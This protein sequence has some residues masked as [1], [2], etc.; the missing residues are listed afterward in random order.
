MRNFNEIKAEFAARQPEVPYPFKNSFTKFYGY[1]AGQTIG[2]FASEREAILADAQVV[3]KHFDKP[4][5]DTAMVA[6]RNW[7][8][9]LSSAWRKQSTSI[10]H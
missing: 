4:A 5:Y 2:T 8:D 3:E 6:Y 9:G 1:A 10:R 7:Q